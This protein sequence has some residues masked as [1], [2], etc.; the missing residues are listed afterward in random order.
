MYYNCNVSSSNRSKK[1]FALQTNLHTPQYVS[2]KVTTK[3][4][5]VTVTFTEVTQRLKGKWKMAESRNEVYKM[6]S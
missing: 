3:C 1:Y 4:V 5:V 6:T 2:P